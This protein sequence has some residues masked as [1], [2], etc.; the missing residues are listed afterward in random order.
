MSPAESTAADSPHGPPVGDSEDLYRCIAHPH[1]WDK[2]EQRITS[3]AFKF[4]C[5]SVDVDVASLASSPEATLARFQP[6]TGLVVFP[7][8]AARELGCDIRME[9]DPNH[10]ENLA[11]AHVYMPS[12]KRKTVTRKL[13]EISTV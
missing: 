12:E 3:V 7:C 9:P 2:H 1:W 4:P 11:H 6:G 10:P 13:V 8:R 5:F